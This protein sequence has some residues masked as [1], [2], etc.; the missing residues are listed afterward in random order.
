MNV[1]QNKKYAKHEYEFISIFCFEKYFI[2]LA[3]VC[4]NIVVVEIRL[5]RLMLH[6][7]FNI[8]AVKFLLP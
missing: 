2:Y 1:I 3:A 6:S 5:K 4:D 8:H 7:C